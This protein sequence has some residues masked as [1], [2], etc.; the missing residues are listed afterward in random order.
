MVA[1]KQLAY[2][3]DQTN[4]LVLQVDPE[5]AIAKSVD[6]IQSQI[7]D[8]LEELVLHLPEPA[9]GVTLEGKEARRYASALADA[10]IAALVLIRTRNGQPPPVVVVG[11]DTA[12]HLLQRLGVWRLEVHAELLPGMPFT[13]GK[14]EH[15][16]NYIIILKAG[17]HGEVHVLATLIEKIHAILNRRTLS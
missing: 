5:A 17:N 9:S 11:G 3:R 14:D 10:A 12:V 6:L 7:T 16:T 1:H 8:D 4:A 13:I 15:A 2:L